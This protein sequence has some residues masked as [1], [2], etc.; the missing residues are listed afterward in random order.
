MPWR[1]GVRD[2]AWPLVPFVMVEDAIV[3]AKVIQNDM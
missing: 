2:L 1:R 3:V